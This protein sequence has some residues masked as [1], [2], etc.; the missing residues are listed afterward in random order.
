LALALV[1]GSLA[2]ILSGL[3]LVWALG[4]SR[5][6]ALSMAPKSI[7]TPIAMDVSRQIGGAPA[8]TAALAIVGGI[9]AASVGRRLLTVLRIHD[10]RA[11]GFAAGVAGSGV[12]AAEAASLGG[13]AAAFAAL[14]VALNGVVTALVTPALVALP[15]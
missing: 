3:A 15:W 4:G 10:H 5:I 12:A 2:S 6:I 7:T 1:C 11:H 13:L 8:L 14:G 9:F